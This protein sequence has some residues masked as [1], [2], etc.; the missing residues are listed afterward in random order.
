MAVKGLLSGYSPIHRYFS[1][2]DPAIGDYWRRGARERHHQGPVVHTSKNNP[3][4]YRTGEVT[5][6]EDVV[7][8]KRDLR[9]RGWAS[10]I[11]TRTKGWLCAGQ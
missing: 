8:L 11:R 1:G 2:K 5:A 9:G 10:N 7:H 4:H 3:N 6:C